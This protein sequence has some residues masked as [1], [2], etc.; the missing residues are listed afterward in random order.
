MKT[1][2]KNSR[3][4]A[5]AILGTFV[6][7]AGAAVAVSHDVSQAPTSAQVETVGRFVVTPKS[8][9]FVAPVEVLGRFV[10]TQHTATF[11]P[12]AV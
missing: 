6:F 5:A 2:Y 12:A 9:K 8:M 10:V 3:L 1:L 7:S 11:V 4:I